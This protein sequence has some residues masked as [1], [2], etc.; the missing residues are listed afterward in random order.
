MSEQYTIQRLRY[1]DFE[2]NDAWDDIF[3]SDNILLI[4]Q[5][6][7]QNLLNEPVGEWRVITGSTVL[8]ILALESNQ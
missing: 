4:H 2:G 8:D 3:Q 5:Y 7:K 6:A 1:W